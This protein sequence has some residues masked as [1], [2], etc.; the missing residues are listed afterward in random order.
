[1]LVELILTKLAKT[2]QSLIASSIFQDLPE[3]PKAAVE[4]MEVDPTPAVDPAVESKE[5]EESKEAGSEDKDRTTK[6]A[7]VAPPKYTAPVDPTTGDL[8]PECTVYLR[9]LL[10]LANLDAGHVKQVSLALLERRRKFD[11]EGS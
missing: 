8:L 5:K 9:L 7:V 11:L 2:G 4:E 3:A 6:A 1:L 10:I